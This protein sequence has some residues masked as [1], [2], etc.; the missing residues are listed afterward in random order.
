MGTVISWNIP[1]WITILLMVA[2]GY[3]ATVLLIQLLRMSGLAQG[4]NDNSPGGP[5]MA[6]FG[7]VFNR[8]AMAA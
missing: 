5:A 3:V 4:A 7:S 8:N 6:L 2:L 1:N